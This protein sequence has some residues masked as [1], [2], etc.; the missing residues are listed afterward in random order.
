[1]LEDSI[2]SAGSKTQDAGFS[3]ERKEPLSRT[4]EVGH[5]HPDYQTPGPGSYRMSSEFGIYVS[6]KFKDAPD[7]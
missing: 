5:P 1:M 3:G 2:E 4:P 6:S 7:K